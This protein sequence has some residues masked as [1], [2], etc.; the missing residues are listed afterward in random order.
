MPQADPEAL[1]AAEQAAAEAPPAP[2][3]G[4]FSRAAMDL[5]IVIPDALVLR[6]RD[7]RAGSGSMALGNLNLTIGGTLDL[8]KSPGTTPMILGSFGVVR[9]FYEFQGRRFEVTRGSSVSF[10]GSDPANPTLNVTGERDVQGVTARVQVTG[11]LRRPRLALS[12]DPALDEGDVLSLIVFNQPINQLGESEQ[13]D[14][15]DRAGALAMGTL[16]T[17]LSD[18]IGR[19]LDVDLFEIR[20]PGSRAAGEL[21]VGRQVNDRFFI[22]FQ[23]QFAGGEASRLSFEYQ[24]TDALRILTSVAQGVERAKRSRNQDTAGIDLIYLVRY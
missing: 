23:Q 5:D 14:L 22:G 24:L 15:L 8:T 16:A 11:T 9:G 1:Q 13:V 18:S 17:S 4:L 10:R 2:D 3:T 7:V 6:G 19:A 20:A 21:N 12:S